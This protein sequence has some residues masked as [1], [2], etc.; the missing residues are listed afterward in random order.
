M[1]SMNQTLYKLIITSGLFLASLSLLG[2]QADNNAN[3]TQWPLVTDCDLHYEACTSHNAEQS[4]QLSITPRPIPVARTL[5]VEVIL[6]NIVADKIEIDISG[7]NMYMGFNRIFISET[8][9]NLWQGKSMLAFCTLD[10]MEWQVT[11]ILHH[12]DQEQGESKQT[13][14]PFS[15]I[16][17]N[18]RR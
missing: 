7:L 8:E 13:Q 14:I 6:E 5:E 18:S 3:I 12:K 4:L 16:T 11:V 1:S 10:K 2:C 15:L 9:P 17:T